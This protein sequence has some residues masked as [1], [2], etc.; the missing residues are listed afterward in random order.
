MRNSE[1]PPNAAWTDLTGTDVGSPYT[2][3]YLTMHR[4]RA[5]KRRGG[6][7]KKCD[8]VTEEIDKLLSMFSSCSCI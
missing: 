5:Y 1:S 3:Y 8:D 2:I 6:I 7:R 4:W